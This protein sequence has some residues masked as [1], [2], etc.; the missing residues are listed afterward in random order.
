MDKVLLTNE[1]CVS[2]ADVIAREIIADFA[3]HKSI[4]IKLYGIPRG[5]IP[6]AYLVCSRDPIF[7]IVD[8]PAEADAL[9]DDIV[10]TGKTAVRYSQEYKTSVY[11]LVDKLGA[12]R[13][14]GWVVFPWEG[15]PEKGI[16]DNIVRLLQFVGEDPE[17]EG[18]KETP[19]RVAKAWQSWTSGYALEPGDVLKSFED[20]GEGYDEMVIVRD[21]PFYSHCEHHLAPFFGT[22]TIGYIPNGKI[23]GLS[24]LSRLLDVFAKR[25]QVQERLTNQIA[26]ALMEDLK[27]KGCAVVIKARHMCME[28]R[29]VCK[30]GHHTITSALRGVVMEKPEVRAEFMALVK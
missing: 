1:M 5:G 21:I 16:E 9:I 12:D 23:V 26:E 25:L 10:D 3:G 15:S 17:R 28:S 13:N 24:K 20:G 22:A 6:A 30:Q 14:L 27:A 11:P 29:G 2:R 7:E 8:T 18:L 4:K 19:T